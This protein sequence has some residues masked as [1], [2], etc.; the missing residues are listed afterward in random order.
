MSL[1]NDLQNIYNIKNDIKLSIES[2]LSNSID[3]NFANYSNYIN[4]IAVNPL[5]DGTKFQG[6]TFINSPDLDTSVM[7]DM[8]N[9][10]YNC[11]NLVNISEFSTINVNNMVNMFY[12]CNNLSNSSY[13]NIA[14]SLPLA[15]NL[16]NLYINNLGLNIDKF[17]AV[18]INILNTKGYL[19][20]IPVQPAEPSQFYTITWEG[21]KDAFDSG[22]DL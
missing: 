10:Y 2:K 17:D 18:Q 6:S 15:I 20:A 7:I 14:N 9:M 11:I 21:D 4:S 8:S 1:K 5:P 16:S 12:N 22:E 19:D 3:L 13:A